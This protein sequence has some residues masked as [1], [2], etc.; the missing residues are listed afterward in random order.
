MAAILRPR[1]YFHAVFAVAA[2]LVLLMPVFHEQLLPIFPYGPQIALDELADD[3]V[4]VATYARTNT[5][6]DSL[7]LT[8]PDDGQFR[9]TAE[10]AIVVDFLGFPIPAVGDAGMAAKIIRLLWHP[11]QN[12]V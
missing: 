3:D 1:K 11:N 12:R 8:P 9:L 4:S 6:P 10:R 5:A 2:S 7:F